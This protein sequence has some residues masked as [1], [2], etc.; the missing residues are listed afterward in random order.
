MHWK[1]SQ[2]TGPRFLHRRAR[3]DLKSLGYR[4]Q[5]LTSTGPATYLMDTWSRTVFHL[6]LK[7]LHPR[8]SLGP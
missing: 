1:F 7:I 5:D 3:S 6:A 4:A 8:K 2:S